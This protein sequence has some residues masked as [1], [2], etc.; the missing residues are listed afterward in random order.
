MRRASARPIPDDPEPA[1]QPAAPNATPVS[2]AAPPEGCGPDAA[3][4][5]RR[6]LKPGD[7]GPA[8]R[9][10]AAA[11]WSSVEPGTAVRVYA[12]AADAA[13]VPLITDLTAFGSQSWY[14][15]GCIRRN[16]SDEKLFTSVVQ[17]GDRF[18]V[19]ASIQR[20]GRLLGR[21]AIELASGETG[22]ITL[23]D[24]RPV[25]VSAIARPETQA[26]IEAAQETPG[27]RLFV[28]VARFAFEG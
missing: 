17:V 3:S 7:F 9:I 12:T 14:R 20:Q 10:H 22:T 11:R 24:G 21:G 23:P 26:E 25:S 15:V 1:A 4:G 13:G 8:R 19:T 16:P 27:G 5:E 18:T 2:L 28:N 6:R